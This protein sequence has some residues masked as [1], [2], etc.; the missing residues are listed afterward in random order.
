MLN[1]IKRLVLRWTIG[2]SMPHSHINK[3]LGMS[4]R[5]LNCPV[6]LSPGEDASES[7]TQRLNS[8][9]QLAVLI[10]CEEHLQNWDIEHLICESST[11]QGR[12]YFWNSRTAWF[13]LR[14]G[15]GGDLA[16]TV[17][18]PAAQKTGLVVPLASSS[19]LK[20]GTEM[21]WAEESHREEEM[22]IEYPIFWS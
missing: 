16:R 12:N 11:T 4:W 9:Y 22:F 1:K 17:F 5:T 18:P 15:L 21:S 13:L 2:H 8:A 3:D 10:N 19:L 14:I 20:A 6:L 7:L